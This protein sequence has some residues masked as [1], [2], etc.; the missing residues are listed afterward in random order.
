MSSGICCPSAIWEVKG[1]KSTLVSR[2]R[3]SDAKSTEG[4]FAA[5]RVRSR[6]RHQEK[7]FTSPCV[8][9]SH[10]HTK[11]FTTPPLVCAE[12]VNI[13]GVCMCVVYCL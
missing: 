4:A 1:A 6:K 13:H 12:T 5:Q 10:T 8:S 3:D 9:L 11:H 2:L 7:R